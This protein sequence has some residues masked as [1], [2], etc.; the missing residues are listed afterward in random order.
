MATKEEK[1]STRGRAHLLFEMARGEVVKGGWHDPAVHEALDLCLS[2]KGCKG[3]CP[4][5]VDMPTYKAEF[6]SHYYEGKLR[7]LRAHAFGRIDR[8]SRYAARFP[9]LANAMMGRA[10]FSTLAKKLLHV[11]NERELTPYAA[12]SFVDWYRERAPQSVAGPKVMLWAD[13]FSN[14]FLPERAKAATRVLE[15]AGFSVALPATGLCCGR[16]LYEW[17]ML[18]LAKEYLRDV[19]NAL[20]DDIRDGTPLVVLEPA[21]ASVFRDE[22][23]NLFPF[24]EQA[25]RLSGQVLLLSEFIERHEERFKLGQLHRRAVVHAHCHHKSVLKTEAYERVMKKIGLDYT[26]LDSGCCGMAGSFGFEDS[27]YELSMRCAERVLLP[28]V[29]EADTDTLVLANGFSCRE[30]IRQSVGRTTLHLAEVLDL[31]G[32]A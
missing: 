31:A 13:T 19:M 27:K 1:H 22:L 9:R 5:K 23:G 12:S 21:C 8:L 20:H 32:E 30:Q 14:Y 24:D 28:A 29:R 2:C 3:E 26:V 7:P 10:P 4:V 15:R 18:D 17:G 6:L 16:P 11:A 25:K